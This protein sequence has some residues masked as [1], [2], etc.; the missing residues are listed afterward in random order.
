VSKE[1]RGGTDASRDHATRSKAESPSRDEER[2]DEDAAAVAP[3][4]ASSPGDSGPDTS[5]E[6]PPAPAPATLVVPPEPRPA[7]WALAA[8]A[9]LGL[10]LLGA[11]LPAALGMPRLVAPLGA[12]SIAASLAAMALFIPFAWHHPSLPPGS[13]WVWSALLVLATPL[14]APAFWALVVRGA[15]GTSRAE[16]AARWGHVAR[17]LALLGTGGLWTFLLM[18]NEA[19]LERG[20]L[21]G[22]LTMLLAL[23]GL[24]DLFGL[25][26]AGGARIPWRETVLAPREGEPIWLSPLVTVPLALAV[27]ALGLPLGGYE[28]L[29]AVLV[30]ALL[31]LLPSALRRPGLLVF[32]VASLL[33]LPLLGTYGLW[34]PWETHYGEVAREILS[35]D[36]WISLWW[37]QEDWFW[38]KPI[39][40]FWSEALSM[41]AL[42]VDFHPDANPAH[43]EWAIRLPHYLLS[44]GALLSVYALVSRVVSKRAGAITALVLA[45]TPHFF[46]LA[47]QAITD[48]PFVA[49][50]TMAMSMLGLAV[51]EDPDR[52][53]KRYALGPVTVS[54]RHLLIAALSAVVLPQVLY[55]LSRNVTFMEAM[56]AFGWHGDQF[57]HGSAGNHGIPGNA[58][59]HD[60]EPHLSG[61]GAQPISQGI[62]W[63]LGYAWILYLL[64]KEWRAQTLYIFAFYLFCGLAFMAKGIPGFALPGLVALLFLTGARR[65]DLLLEGRLRVA[66]GM[67]VVIVTGL[68]WYVAM[69]IRHGPPFTERLLIHDHINRLTAGVHGDTGSLEY[70]VEQLG[71]GLFPWIALAPLAL[72]GWLELK[73]TGPSAA[74]ADGKRREAVMLVTLWLASAFTLFSAMTTKFHHYIFPA[75]PPAAILVGITLDKLFGPEALRFDWRRV[76]ITALSVIAP[77]P[78]VIG[79]AG[80][81]GDV[82]GRLPEGVTGPAAA[83]WVLENPW[84][85]TTSLS[86]LGLGALVFAAAV[87]LWRSAPA[88]SDASAPDAAAE[89]SGWKPAAVTTGLL[90]APVLVAVVGRDLS[91][92]TDARPQGYERLIHLFVYNYGRPWPEGYDYRPILTGFAIV[93]T[94][95]VLVS[96]VKVLRPLAARAFLGVAL[97]FTLWALDV[98]LIDLSPHWGQRELVQ[99]Y[100]EVRT[101]PEEPL[102]AWQMNWK[103]ENF[104]T[105]NRVSV[106]VQL[107][108]RELINWVNQRPDTTAYFLLEHSRLA[109]LRGAV[110]NAEFEEVTDMAL[111]NKFILVRARIRERPA[112]PTPSG[113]PARGA[114]P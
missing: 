93:A 19:Q 20:P 109:S 24:L 104:Y 16:V 73:P 96:A 67:L 59:V 44:M 111:N 86:L 98:Y 42:G 22:M 18:A 32:T 56:P 49:C 39:L 8:S 90:A 60:V 76:G 108:N 63:L 62:F 6:D 40:I 28:H 25:W 3:P 47:H 66:A 84:P 38:S 110:R 27:L 7:A 33:Y 64:R 92:V 11:A 29:P 2:P 77:A 102:V 82:R 68:P 55:L 41:G 54:G 65:W 58:P 61:P 81:W 78:V 23:A 4:A 14:A 15:P 48:M 37:A 80:L 94:V 83:D 31:A 45:T 17:G 74:S 91:W 13:R 114:R 71:Y 70:F 106:F 89:T 46:L 97:V 43:P 35:R 105:G 52:E 51:V 10:A 34:D 1:N 72:A 88:G 85:A 9:A 57:M 21:W 103:G 30:V 113:R 53:V 69:Y 5:A 107:D 79:V 100:Y 112:P 12:A 36:D 26:H 95:V 87:W 101:G 75:V 99:R 50:M